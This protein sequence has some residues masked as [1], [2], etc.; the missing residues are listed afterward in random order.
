MENRI[1]Q[2][3]EEEQRLKYLQQRREHNLETIEKRV[4]ELA[5]EKQKRA[6]NSDKKEGMV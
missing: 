3:H 6:R 5:I 4:H 2:N 1:Q